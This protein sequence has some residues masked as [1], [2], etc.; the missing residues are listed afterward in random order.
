MGNASDRGSGDRSNDIVIVEQ[1]TG[2]R[3]DVVGDPV[4]EFR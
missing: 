1:I 3:D 4:H 2:G